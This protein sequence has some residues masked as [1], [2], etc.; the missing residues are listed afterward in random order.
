M[1]T[2]SW[3]AKI[4]IPSAKRLQIAAV[5]LNYGNNWSGFC[6]RKLELVGE[7]VVF[8]LPDSYKIQTETCVIDGDE[9]YLEAEFKNS[10]GSRTEVLPMHTIQKTSNQEKPLNVLV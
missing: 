2:T 8:D 6:R 7:L 10:T 9:F 1:K 5:W 3:E 4:P